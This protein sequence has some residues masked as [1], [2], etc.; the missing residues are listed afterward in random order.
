M[1]VIAFFNQKGGVGK[2]SIACNVAAAIA[3]QGLQTLVIDLDAQ[4]NATQY[5]SGDHPLTNRKSIADFFEASLGLGLFSSGLREMVSATPTRNLQII[6]ADG[7]LIE[8][9]AKLESRYK[10]FK[11]RDALVDLSERLPIDVVILDCPPALNFYSMSALMAA[12]RVY[13]PFDCDAFALNGIK[14]VMTLVQEVREDHNT[15]LSIGGVIAN[16]FIASAKQP[17]L[18]IKAIEETGLQVL[19]PY[20][21]N[22]VI[23]RESHDAREPLVQF[24]PK[25]KLTLEFVQL[26]KSILNPDKQ[27]KAPNSRRAPRNDST[28]TKLM[29]QES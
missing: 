21:S 15:Q 8:L 23:M 18:A 3:R 16:H 1:L 24:K 14:D 29:P 2:T 9:Q 25:H 12:Q 20:L 13:V 10:V 26:A 5:L 28:K 6:P 27:E 7:R 22:S 11:L 17:T 19:K 4:A